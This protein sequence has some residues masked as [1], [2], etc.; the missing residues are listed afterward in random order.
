MEKKIIKK[1]ICPGC[2]FS[3]GVY[4]FSPSIEIGPGDFRIF[5]FYSG[6]RGPLYC[7]QCKR[8]HLLKIA[9]K[10]NLSQEQKTFLEKKILEKEKKYSTS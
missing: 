2:G 6:M 7:N 4:K 8:K 1:R 10:K 3:G 5:H 9:D